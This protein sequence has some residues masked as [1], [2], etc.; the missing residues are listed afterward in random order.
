MTRALVA[1]LAA[2]CTATASGAAA[3]NAPAPQ[4]PVG[5]VGTTPRSVSKGVL[6]LLS[7]S[8]VPDGTASALQ[9]DRSGGSDDIGITLGQ[10]GA[11]FTFSGTFPLYVEGYLGYGRYDPRFVF[12]DG[13]EQRQVRTRWD[14]LALTIG[15]GCDSRL[16]KNLHQRPILN[17]AVA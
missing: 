17:A 4:V 16:A 8:V 15:D 14:Q 13:E 11:G 12:S 6:G 7:F 2:L 10:I 3:Q 9:I 1:A 5:V